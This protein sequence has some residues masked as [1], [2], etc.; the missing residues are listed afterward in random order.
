MNACSHGARDLVVLGRASVDRNT[1]RGAVATQ[2]LDTEHPRI[3][4]D[5]A[6]D[7]RIL[8]QVCSALLIRSSASAR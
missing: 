7:L 8:A 1:D 4:E 5:E 6:P 3:V 2:G